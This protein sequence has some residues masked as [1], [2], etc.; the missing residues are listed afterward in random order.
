MKKNYASNYFHKILYKIESH[1]N[2][3]IS[4]IKENALVN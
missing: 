4:V 2:L 3:S 1:L